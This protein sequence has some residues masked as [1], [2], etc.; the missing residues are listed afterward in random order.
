MVEKERGRREG[1]DPRI[2]NMPASTSLHASGSSDSGDDGLLSGSVPERAQ[3]RNANGEL[4]MERKAW[5]T[6]CA[7]QD[8]LESFLCRQCDRLPYEPVV[9]MNCGHV[10]CWS[11]LFF[12]CT[13]SHGDGNDN[14][15]VRHSAQ[16]GYGDEAGTSA[17]WMKQKSHLESI[18]MSS[19]HCIRCREAFKLKQVV[20]I[21][22]N[23]GKNTEIRT[24]A[25]FAPFAHIPPRPPALYRRAM[26]HEH[27][28]D[29]LSESFYWA[30]EAWHYVTIDMMPDMHL[31]R[32]SLSH[33]IHNVHF[34]PEH[35][36]TDDYDWETFSKLMLVGTVALSFFLAAC[37]RS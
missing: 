5:E 4:T 36:M 8:R 29:G 22:V 35:F 28:H 19:S 15:E 7:R 2:E 32:L 30:F 12:S 16:A 24:Q 21:Y 34:F 13:S 17:G 23:D 37:V 11:C 25:K 26:I 9:T 18:S 31:D 14:E 10:Y 20:P 6:S 1:I 27:A 33:V 3:T